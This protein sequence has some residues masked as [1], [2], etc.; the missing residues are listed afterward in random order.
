[1]AERYD[2]DFVRAILQHELDDDTI[3][4]TSFYEQIGD[5]TTLERYA[6]Q[7]AELI[8]DQNKQTYKARGV[9]AQN[10]EADIVNITSNYICPLE[11]SVRLDVAYFKQLD[12]DSTEDL[13]DIEYVNSA[14]VDLIDNVK[15]RK[16]D[17]IMGEEGDLY[18]CKTPIV[19][20]TAKNNIYLD[21][22]VYMVNTS[23]TYSF[24]N[25]DTQEVIDALIDDNVGTYQFPYD[26]P[27]GTTTYTFYVQDATTADLYEV[28]A[29]YTH[30]SGSDDTLTYV[31]HTLLEDTYTKYKVSLSVNN[32]QKDL[33]YDFNGTGRM[34][35]LFSGQATIVDENVMLGNDIIKTTMKVGTSGETYPVEPLEI[36][37]ATKVNDADNMYYQTSVPKPKTTNTHISSTPTYSFVID[38]SNALL[39]EMYKLARYQTMGTQIAHINY[40]WTIVEYM[41]K[42]GTLNKYT[43]KAKIDDISIVPTNGDVMVIKASF[44]LGD[45]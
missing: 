40:V 31:R 41:Y 23:A 12:E 33:P 42:Y 5:P 35:L 6:Q 8:N 36:P 34:A 14:V 32:I 27:V 7:V 2:I 24:G 3:F 45:Y 30:T 25:G 37:T 13:S 20:S 9:V 26:R 38:T 43:M 28:V 16:F 4:L 15:G 19:G 39:L 17:V 18:V 22:D 29:T 11:Y 10:G 44:K 1:M 21:N